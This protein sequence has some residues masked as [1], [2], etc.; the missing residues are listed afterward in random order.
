MSYIAFFDLLGTRGFCDNPDIY[1][2]NINRFNKAVVQT[3]SL[4]LGYG[5]VGIFSDSAY[6]GSNTLQHML[7]FLVTLRDRLMAE[8]LF[9][10]AVVKE[11][12]LNFDSVTP[13]AS[14]AFGVV[15]KDSAIAGLYI[16][17]TSFKGVGIFVDGSISD[18]KIREAGYDVSRCVYMGRDSQENAGKWYPVAYRDI[19]LR[20]S[21]SE[22]WYR[23]MILEI[24]LQVFY[25][26]YM[27]APKYGA[28]YVSLISNF[29][30]SFGEDLKWDMTS[31]KF[32]NAP[33]IFDVV[34]K[35]ITTEYE[36]LSSLPGIDYLIF[37]ILDMVYTT[38]TLTESDKI[39]ITRTFV[40]IESVRKNYLHNLNN[41]PRVLFSND[42]EGGSHWERF[43]RCCQEEFANEFVENLLSTKILNNPI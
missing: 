6:V 12:D 9:F 35:M 40:K 33:L 41:V 39:S 22:K 4:L 23:N 38:S 31:N 19:S 43:I 15:F 21:L 36:M 28:Y 37:M 1:Y 2:D 32:T 3:S 34:Y 26:S 42:R 7:G 14:N 20:K 13:K 17:Q 5:K 25:A 11:G 27:K 10:N 29:I 18:E 30:Q 8:G 24:L 16:A